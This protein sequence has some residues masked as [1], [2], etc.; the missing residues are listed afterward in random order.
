MSAPERTAQILDEAQDTFAKFLTVSDNDHRYIHKGQGFVAPGNTGSVAAAG[1]YYATLV[2]PPASSG[3][4]V[5]LRPSQLASTANILLMQVHEGSTVGSLG[6]AF[7]P[8]N[9]NRNRQAAVLPKSLVYMGSGTVT[10]G[11]LIQQ[12]A[13]GSGGSGSGNSGGGMG[14]TQERVLKPST[15]YTFKFTNIGTVT[16]TTGYFELFFYEEGMGA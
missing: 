13:V 7:T 15:T 16:A 12:W 14:A 1:L 9:C 5:H 3:V 8:V 10:D 2:T 11:T 6:S 4:Y